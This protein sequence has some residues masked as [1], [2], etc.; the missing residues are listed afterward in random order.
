MNAYEKRKFAT[1]YAQFER[2]LTLQGYSQST[3]AAYTLGIRRLSQ[4]CDKCPDKHLKK[5]DFVVVQT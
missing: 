5:D 2:R 1:Q 3:I 4:W